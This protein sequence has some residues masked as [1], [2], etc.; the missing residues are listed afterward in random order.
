[1]SSI[2][3]SIETVSNN[4]NFETVKLTENSYL[5]IYNA[6]KSVLDYIENNFDNM[7]A[8]HPTYENNEKSKVMHYTKGT[9]EWFEVQSKRWFRSYLKIPLLNVEYNKSSY[10][11]CGKDNVEIEEKL[12]EVF[13]PIYD[14]VK[15]N[16]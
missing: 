8:L 5:K 11:F 14:Y 4:L 15:K 13:Q 3:D 9:N 7:F 1:M 16:R 2:L 12:P 10:M 6:D